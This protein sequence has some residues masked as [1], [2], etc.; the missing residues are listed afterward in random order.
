MIASAPE[1]LGSA[2]RLLHSR[3]IRVRPLRELP[4][5]SGINLAK[6]SFQGDEKTHPQRQNRWLLAARKPHPHRRER[7][8]KRNRAIAPL[9]AGR[10]CR[11]SRNLASARQCW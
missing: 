4:P 1:P 3:K 6:L 2:V 8:P 9:A 10:E 7:T 11:S 5:A